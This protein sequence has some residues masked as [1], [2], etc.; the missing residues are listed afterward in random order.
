[1]R[2]IFLAFVLLFSLGNASGK[3]GDLYDRGEQDAALEAAH[4]AAESGDPVGHAWLGRFYENGEG[5]QTNPR[6]AAFH[7]R[8]AASQGQNYARWRLGV[9]ID[10]G[11]IGGTL[12]EA[13]E[14]FRIAA[15]EDYTNAMVSLAV[16][17]ATGR[18]TALDHDAALASYMRAARMGDSGGVRGVGV[19]FHL[20]QSVQ[21]DSQEAMAWFLLGAAMGNEDAED[22]FYAVAESING[23]D[24]AAVE[25]RAFEIASEL[26]IEIAN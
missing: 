6:T 11:T 7:Y 23:V 25:A 24:E 19:M 15:S 4:I 8:I 16:M 20:G 17:Q 12:E 1:M 21:R 2:T 22:A 14:Y 18:G 10:T 9:M 5:V 26:G 3:I 13:V